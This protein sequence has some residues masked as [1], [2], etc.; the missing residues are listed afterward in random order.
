M[1][2]ISQARFETRMILRHGEQALLNIILPALAMIV[3]AK[4][5][6]PGGG[7]PMSI[8]AAYASGLALAW[9]STAFTSQAIALAFDRRSGVLRMLS[10]TP[11]GPG[12]LW[13]GKLLAVGLVALVEFIVLTAIGLALGLGFTSG[14]I[15]PGLL[16]ALFG[17]AAFLGL[18]LLLGGTLRPEAVLALANIAWVALAGG[19]GLLLPVDDYPGIWSTII[20]YLPSGAL[21]EA[22]RDIADAGGLPVAH[23]AVL[24]VWAIGGGLA[25][26]R[27]FRWDSK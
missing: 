11:L 16:T 1:K 8:S 23:L 20:S 13:A 9:T 3:L 21:G 2:V 4:V 12:G 18:G 14:V 17:L 7:A 25:A 19:G 5:P 10:T 6:V 26:A 15:L 27:F 24:A 22:M